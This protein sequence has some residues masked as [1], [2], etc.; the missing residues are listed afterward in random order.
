MTN[1][2]QHLSDTAEQFPDHPAIILDDLSLSYREVEAA[3]KQLS[4][5]L[6]EHG[7][8]PGD[9]VAVMLPNLPPFPVIYYGA[10]RAGA[11]VV[12]M[13]P[14]FKRREIEH[15]L[16]DSG[17]STIFAMPSEEVEAAAEATGAELVPVGA[18]GLSGLLDGVE[19]T[20][21]MVD[22][23]DD[24]TA[25]ILYTSGTTGRPKGAELTHHNL[26]SNQAS[27]AQTLLHLD[28]QDVV[29]GC[30]PLFHVFGMTCG[31]NS[32]FA[33]GAALTLIPRFDPAKALEVIERDKVT[34]FEGVPTMYG[35]MLA[36]AGHAE[37]VP[38]LSSLR[39]AVSGGSSMPV[40]VLRTF[41]EAFSCV[42][43]EGYGLSETSPVASFNH[44]DADRK[45]GSIGTPIRGVE[46]MLLDVEG[47]EAAEGEIGEIA[48][49]GENIMAGYWANEDA[50]AEAIVD[51]WF[52]SG[53]LARR[54]SDGYYEIVDRKKD[55][56]I[57]GGMNIYPREIE[58]VLYEHSA[59]AEAAV[60]GVPH[61]EYGEEVAAYVVIAEGAEATEDELREHVK[62]Q[63]AAYKYPREV[64][65]IPELPKGAT[66]KILKRELGKD[67]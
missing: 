57:R 26:N 43:L 16:S 7:V 13:N 36:A 4:A 51:G 55:M 17:A 53:D 2:A 50:S 35:A 5:W 23:G 8:T 65:L 20:D 41:E 34:V 6:V 19:P 44:P 66:G 47:N 46:M 37:Q 1:L 21:A 31:M 22:R 27:T 59:V 54:D 64:H 24:D 40:E 10:L 63:V 58:E 29:M 28:E 18:D 49:R 3:A 14:L 11:I 25:V 56:I 62:A 39:T 42:I 60:V 32:A 15:Y 45:P 52:R 9:R 67:K 12:P 33:C 38:D 61:D 48:I 30:L